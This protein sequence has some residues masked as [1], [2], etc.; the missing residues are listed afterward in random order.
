VAWI[1]SYGHLARHRKLRKLASLLG[2]PRPAAAGYLHYLW[3]MT[4]E[5][6]PDGD[7]TG[8]TADDLA[9]AL[10]WPGDNAEALV[11]ALREA[12]WL[13]GPPKG[14]WAVHDWADWTSEFVQE[15]ARRRDASRRANHER[16][17]VQRGVQDP[18]CPY[19]PQASPSSVPSD[20][21]RN[22]TGLRPE[23]DRNP[24]GTPTDVRPESLDKKRGEE[25]RGEEKG[26]AASASPARRSPPRPSADAYTLAD[27]LKQALETRG[28]TVFA[29]D[30]HLT[31]ASA[32]Q[33]VLNAGLS[34]ADAQAL[35]EWTL[36][37]PFWGPK[38][39]HWRDIRNRV[40]EWQQRHLT[41]SARDTP[42]RRPTLQERNEAA[43]RM[44]DALERRTP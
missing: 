31:S 14:P 40:A 24:T 34:V 44:A 27:A 12:G 17:H 1:R 36:G 43:F 33:S 15:E 29:R 7:L 20:S 3:W 39:G 10:E 16:W 38:V 9:D 35:M 26:E 37:H 32:A 23:S 22:P 21:D 18:T 30:W 5:Q 11:A 42:G 19:C 4:L 41:P 8:F 2:I 13:D 6:A 25:R 28:V